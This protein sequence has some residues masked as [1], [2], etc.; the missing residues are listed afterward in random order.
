MRGTVRRWRVQLS[1][2]PYRTVWYKAFIIA[3]TRAYRASDHWRIRATEMSPEEAD[4]MFAE[5][6]R[7]ELPLWKHKVKK[8]TRLMLRIIFTPY[9]ITI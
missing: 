1:L 3:C 8:D 5:N 4:R 2:L 7:T 9:S 6:T